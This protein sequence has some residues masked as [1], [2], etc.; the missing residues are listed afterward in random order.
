[1]IK[2]KI[3]TKDR[4]VYDYLIGTATD[5]FAGLEAYL[6]DIRVHGIIL[7]ISILEKLEEVTWNNYISGE[8]GTKYNWLWENFK[9]R[10]LLEDKK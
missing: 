3:D 7:P 5:D 1:M 2:T 6:F 4:L 10:K 9:V 8:I